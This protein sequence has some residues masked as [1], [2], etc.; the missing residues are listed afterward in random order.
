[1]SAYAIVRT[2][3]RNSLIFYIFLANA[4]HRVSPI[5]DLGKSRPQPVTNDRGVIDRVCDVPTLPL[6][7]HGPVGD[8]QCK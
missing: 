4:R 8:S 2:S 5:G 1:M 3:R 7:H 6:E